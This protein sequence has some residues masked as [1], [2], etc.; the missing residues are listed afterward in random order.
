MV[1]S[2]QFPYY[3]YSQ[4]I[5]NTDREQRIESLTTAAAHANNIIFIAS[6]CVTIIL[7]C[8]VFM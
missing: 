5:Q 3:Y 2:Q 7:T 6:M 8:E 4:K 1:V